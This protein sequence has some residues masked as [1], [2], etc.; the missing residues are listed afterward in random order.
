MPTST[1]S[2]ALGTCSISWEGTAVTRFILPDDRLAPTDNVARPEWIDAL[3]ARARNHFSG[4]LENFSDV[5]L[6][7]PRVSEFQK[8]VYLR[9]LAIPPGFT[10]SYGDIS[11]ELGLGHEGARS[12]G[13]A[14][15]A[16]PWPLI[17]PCHRVVAANGRMT[18]F[19]APGGIQTKTRLLALEGAEL[20]SE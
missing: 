14:L 16:N 5:P 4:H 15:G 3:I 6:D 2:T 17:V 13:A 20:L 7:W 1:F 11:K 10:R 9:T 18:G 8:K 12:V 19:S